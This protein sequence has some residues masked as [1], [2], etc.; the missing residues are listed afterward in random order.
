M[1]CNAYAL[2]TSTNCLLKFNFKFQIQTVSE[3]TWM[4]IERDIYTNNFLEVGII[5]IQKQTRTVN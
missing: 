2:L 5:Y 1:K 3:F 4:K